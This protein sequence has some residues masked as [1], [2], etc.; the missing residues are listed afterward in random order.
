MSKKPATR[1]TASDVER[2]LRLRTQMSDLLGKMTA[3]SGKN[4]DLVINKFKLSMI[5]EQLAIAN[6]ILGSDGKPIKGFEVFDE[7]SLATNSDVVVVLSQYLACLEI[8]RSAHVS[9]NEDENE[10]Y[11]DTSD[12]DDLKASPPSGD[13]E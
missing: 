3:L 12:R 8:W 6:E 5:N 2:F 13:T 1:F 7:S 9:V 11:W 10:W 4:P